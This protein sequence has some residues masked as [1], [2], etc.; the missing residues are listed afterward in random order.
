MSAMTIRQVQALLSYL[1]YDPGAAD[2]VSGPKTA[3][4]VRAFQEAAGLT[5]DGIPGMKTWAALKEAVAND[6]FAHAQGT[7]DSGQPPDTGNDPAAPGFWGDIHNFSRDEFRCKCGGKYCGGFPA[8]P[9]EKLVR[10]AERVREHFGQPVTVSSGLRCPTHNAIEGGVANSRHITGKAM[11]FTV[12]GVSGAVVLAYCQG[13][14][15]AGELRYAYRIR[16]SDFVH[17]DVL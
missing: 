16:D 2:G 8:E 12:R 14:I 9:E 15:N 7:P 11:D 13:L 17:M 5:T 6:R 10:L 3:A 1:G 4:A